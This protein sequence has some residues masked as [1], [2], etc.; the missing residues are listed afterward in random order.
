M[1]EQESQIPGATAPSSNTRRRGRTVT[2]ILLKSVFLET[3][4]MNPGVLRSP[5]E[6]FDTADLEDAMVQ[7]WCEK[8]TGNFKHSPKMLSSF[9]GGIFG[10]ISHT[11]WAPDAAE[12]KIGLCSDRTAIGRLSRFELAY[13]S[14]DGNP[15]SATLSMLVVLK[16][17][18]P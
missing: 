9:D 17:Q 18:L 10:K 11:F 13:E 15:A 7:L 5:F 14:T 4:Q 12:Y 2:S 6:V 8:K 3:S 1:S 16:Y